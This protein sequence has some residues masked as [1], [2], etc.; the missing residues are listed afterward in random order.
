MV[1]SPEQ[2]LQISSISETKHLFDSKFVRFGRIQIDSANDFL[3]LYYDW[4]V[5]CFA[6]AYVLPITKRIVFAKHVFDKHIGAVAAFV[7]KSIPRFRIVMCLHW[8]MQQFEPCLASFRSILECVLVPCRILCL[9]PVFLRSTGID[10]LLE[11]FVAAPD[12]LAL[13]TTL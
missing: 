7:A 5:A 13:G 1:W 11:P 6:R 4:H 9:L 3:V 12:R 8:L 10:V 2:V